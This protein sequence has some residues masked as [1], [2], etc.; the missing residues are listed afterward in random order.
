MP[1]QHPKAEAR[2]GTPSQLSPSPCHSPSQVATWFLPCLARPLPRTPT[3]GGGSGQS[4]VCVWGAQAGCPNPDTLRSCGEANRPCTRRWEELVWVILLPLCLSIHLWVCP[5]LLEKDALLTAH[6]YLD[7][8]SDGV[9]YKCL[10]ASG[11]SDLS[12]SE[13]CSL[14][15][16]PRIPSGLC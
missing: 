13:Q 4:S 1:D 5:L 10:V 12:P 15:T 6:I 8:G 11:P 16:G 2:P 7:R 14:N 3:E 9:R